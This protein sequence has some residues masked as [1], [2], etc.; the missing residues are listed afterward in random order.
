MDR[1]LW[2]EALHKQNVEFEKLLQVIL[3]L[4]QDQKKD[5]VVSAFRDATEEV[6]VEIE[7]CVVFRNLALQFDEQDRLIDLFTVVEGTTKRTEI[8]IQEGP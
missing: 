5:T 4:T 2:I 8:L 7:D 1:R 3:R 6:A